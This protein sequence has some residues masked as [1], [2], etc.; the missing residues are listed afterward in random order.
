MFIS[1]KKYA[2]LLKA[3]MMLAN[4]PYLQQIIENTDGTVTFVFVQNG[5]VYNFIAERGDI[6]ERILN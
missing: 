6:E 4:R 3:I 5:K 1:I 2:Q